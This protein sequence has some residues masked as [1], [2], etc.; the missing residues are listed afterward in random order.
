M[1]ERIIVRQDSDFITEILAA[2]PHN[3]ESDEFEAVEHV[4][5]LTPYGMLM[6]SLGSCTGLVLH[7]YAQHHDIALDE[8][9]MHVSY[10]RIFAED[11]EQCDSIEEYMEHFEM[12]I[13][14]IGD[15]TD[16]DR[17]R[18]NVVSKHCPIHKIISHGADVESHLARE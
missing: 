12:D 6:A 10:D 9:E 1:G 13:N 16:Q 4:H 18:L 2:D 17:H 11:C 15:L 14:P 5:Q 3:P 7:T 8:V